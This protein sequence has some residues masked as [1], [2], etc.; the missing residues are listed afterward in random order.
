MRG[1]GMGGQCMLWTFRF[2]T[3]DLFAILSLEAEELKWW[4][5]EGRVS[6]GGHASQ[7]APHLGQERS[8]GSS[9]WEE[10][11]LLQEGW[12]LCPSPAKDSAA[13]SSSGELARWSTFILVKT[14][15]GQRHC[16]PTIQKQNQKAYD[17]ELCQAREGKRNPGFF[18]K[19]GCKWCF[20]VSFVQ[21]LGTVWR[22]SPQPITAVGFN[23]YDRDHHP[24]S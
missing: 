16:S 13:E 7:E 6:N 14:S 5:C 1:K 19:A 15:L 17:V 18:F 23:F 4:E 11:I 10:D 24:I 9:H 21:P 22:A 20:V 3:I 12:G 8:G 2:W